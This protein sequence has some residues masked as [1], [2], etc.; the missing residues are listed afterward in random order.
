MKAVILAAGGRK[1]LEPL[2]GDLPKGMLPI[3][4]ETV[5][6][7]MI[8]QLAAGG[9]KEIIVVV[10]YQGDKVRAHLSRHRWPCR[11][12]FVDNPTYAETGP[13][14]SATL[15]APFVV[16]QPFCLLDGDV[17]AADL[18]YDLLLGGQDPALLYTPRG[19]LGTE[20]MKVQRADGCLELSKV[21]APGQ[22]L[23][24]FTGLVRFD[25]AASLAFCSLLMG[26]QSA[27]KRFYY[28]EVIN[29]VAGE[30]AFLL[31]A[32]PEGSWIEVD[33]VTD[34]LE[35]VRLFADAT[36]P[37]P[38]EAISE[39]VLLCPGP[40]MVS[41]AVKR[42]LL[43]PNIGHRDVEF[44]ELLTRIRGKLLHAY[45]VGSSAAY[46]DVIIT[47]SGTAANEALLS[48]YGPGRRLLILANG[49]FGLRLADMARCHG[50]DHHTLDFGWANPFDF[51]LIRGALEEGRY[52]AVVAV[53]HETSTGM[54]NP[55]ED[56][57]RL[58]RSQGIDL[59]VDAVSSLGAEELA[60]E[61]AGVT[62]CTA[63]G[64][65]AL[66]SLPGLSFVCGRR[67]A[68]EALK[69]RPAR[70]R[71][72]DLYLHYQY[73]DGLS[74]TPNTPAVSLF[75]A[76]E[77]ALDELLTEGLDTRMKRYGRLVG[78]I[79]QRLQEL[80]LR[81]VIPLSQ[82]SRVLTTVF[83]PEGV[84]PEDLHQWIKDHNFVVYRGKGPLLGRAFQVANI[85]CVD[86]VH[87][88]RF[89]DLLSDRL[90]QVEVPAARG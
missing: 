67:E 74:Q 21:V 33:F 29:Q 64:N 63:S 73:E 55:V 71:Y 23:G 42:A 51:D 5:L 37:V 32:A 54:L 17:V 72:L 31:I 19:V 4:A 1:G 2:S 62:F 11:L 25:A 34:Y 80:G 90:R 77:V 86:E 8:R 40:V 6:E 46:T 18:V 41:P 57:G 83:Y 14:H 58:T 36:Y 82:M 30:H 70:T 38:D 13:I 12:Q 84:D 65:K 66:A 81:F 27:D 48:S 88:I 52:D 49:E 89:L 35:A 47:G 7:R 28:E 78:I 24:E 9:V 20:E 79:R 26:Q 45:G 76:L 16:G 39:Q 87:I 61:Q 85:G 44:S 22:A 75:Y 68:F 3:G 69:K 10:G 56:L 53:H 60:L 43:H 15:A 59:L 50:L